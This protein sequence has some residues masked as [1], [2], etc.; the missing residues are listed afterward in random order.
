[1]EFWGVWGPVASVQHQWVTDIIMVDCAGQMGHQAHPPRPNQNAQ[2]WE[3]VLGRES[4]KKR[5][6]LKG[7]SKL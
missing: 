3:H 2:K 5:A 6:R 7:G 4:R 1:M